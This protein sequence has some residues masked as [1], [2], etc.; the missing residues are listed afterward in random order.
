L[1]ERDIDLIMALSDCIED[2]RTKYD[3]EKVKPLCRSLHSWIN[4]LL[5]YQV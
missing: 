1:C 3:T 5:V 4:L 2:H